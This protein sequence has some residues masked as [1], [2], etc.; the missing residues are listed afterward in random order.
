MSQVTWSDVDSFIDQIAIRYATTPLTGVY[1]IPRGGTVLAVM[2]SHALNIP[3]LQA[4]TK[5]CLVVD[6]ISDT[7]ATLKHYRH[8]GYHT[9]TMFST[10]DTDTPPDYH[11]YIKTDDWVVFPWERIEHDD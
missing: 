1:G 4:P 11:Q 5:G 7:G 10:L 9:A 2:V 8:K 3:L 6:D